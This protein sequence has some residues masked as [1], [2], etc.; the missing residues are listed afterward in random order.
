MNAE[1]GMRNSED[2]MWKV[3]AQS[4]GQRAWRIGQRA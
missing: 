1:V 2:G 4:M 3:R